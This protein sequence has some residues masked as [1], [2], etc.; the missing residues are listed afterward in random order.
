VAAE[1]GSDEPLDSSVRLLLS[2]VGSMMVMIFMVGVGA[3]ILGLT[4]N[5]RRAR[6]DKAPPPPAQVAPPPG[7]PSP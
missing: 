2:V 3:V 4:G 1:A 5:N 7:P 6:E